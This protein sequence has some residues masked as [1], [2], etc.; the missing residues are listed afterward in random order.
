M[1][2]L[3]KTTHWSEV[4]HLIKPYWVSEEKVSAWIRLITI[5][6]LSLAAVYLNVLFNEWNRV[7]YDALQNRDYEV[8]KAQLFRFSYLAVIYIIIAI[9]RIYL[10]QGLQMLWRQWMTSQYMNKWLAHQSYYHTEL[11]Q[12]IDNP[13]QRI[14]QDLNALTNG[15]LSLSL[16]LL[17]SLV[18][19]FSFIAILW[20]ISGSITFMISHHEIVIPGYMVWFALLYAVLGSVI[21]WWIGRPLVVLNFNQER[22]EA[23]FRFGLVR[24]RDSADSIALYHGEAQEKKQ[25]DEKFEDIRSNWWS[26]MRLTKRLNIASTL[27]AQFAIIF[28]ILVAAPRYFSNAIQLGTLMQISSAFG[29]VQGALSWFINAFTDLASWKTCVNRLAGFNSAIDSIAHHTS[30]ITYSISEPQDP[31]ITH[32]LTLRLPQGHDLLCHANLHAQRG[33]KILI[34]GPSG[35]GKSTLLRALAGVWPYGAGEIVQP[36]TQQQKMLF[37]PQRNYLPIGSLRNALCYPDSAEQ[38]DD[39]MLK[40]ILVA[41]HLSHLQSALDM[42]NNWIQQL[43]S[44]EQQRIA[45]ARALIIQPDILYLDETTSA[46]DEETELC[47]YQLIQQH[48]PNTTLFSV[49]H[50]SSVSSFHQIRW[51]FVKQPVAD[52][53]TGYYAPS[54]IEASSIVHTD[55]P[56]LARRESH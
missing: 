34:T 40:E 28:P 36:D 46:L 39:K 32:D 45:F 43:S 47:M 52:E 19:L 44:G 12:S 10:T 11:Q 23:N 6:S 25:L 16:G 31:L 26:I 50:R 56:P 48:L 49:A 1:Q 3:N 13:D 15:T 14:S 7:F 35:C 20:S 53:P 33:D 21:V 41:C 42:S 27:Y 18:T 5:I 2:P 54:R 17:S 38:F 29:Q 22:Y 4:W 51:Q 55:H 37:L 9:Y 30:Q 24:I 8:F